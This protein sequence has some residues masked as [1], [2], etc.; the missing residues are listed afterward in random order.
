MFTS[1]NRISLTNNIR[2]MQGTC[3]Y[4]QR[5]Q[6][7]VALATLSV[8]TEAN[9][10]LRSTVQMKEVLL[11]LVRWARCASTGT[12]EFCPAL[13][14]LISPVKKYFPPHITGTL[15]HFILYP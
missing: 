12:K 3:H 13:A 15:F 2:R 1:V 5:N 11:L 6:R 8:E 4:N 7:G 10:D 14:A 9:G